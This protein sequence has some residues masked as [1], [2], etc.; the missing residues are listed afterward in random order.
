MV[1]L[2]LATDR[3]VLAEGI[4]RLCAAVAEGAG[5]GARRA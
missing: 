5:E 3:D 2:S 1:R 4:R